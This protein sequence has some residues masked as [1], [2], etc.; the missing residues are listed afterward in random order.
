MPD[1]AGFVGSAYQAPSK[2]QNDQLLINW[3]TETDQTKFVGAKATGQPGERGATA[4]YPTPGLDPLA[5]LIEGEVRGLR[6]LPGGELM[7]AVSGDRLYRIDQDYNA[8]EAGTLNTYEGFLGI[9]DNG[10]SAYLTDGASRYTY[11]WTSNTFAVIADGPFPNGLNC[12]EVD[13]YIIYNRPGTNQWGCTDVGEVDS[14]ALN[15]GSKIGSADNIKTLIADHRQV[16]LIGEKTTEFHVDVGS[17]PFPFAIVPGTM[18]QHGIAAVGSLS[19]LGE[20]VAFL[21][22]DSR[23]KATVIMMQGYQ[24]K[25]ISTF[26]IEKAIN[27]YS[28]IDDAIAYTYTQSGHE[29]YMLTFPTA[30]KTWCYDLAEDDWHQRSWRDPYGVL[31]R[32]RSNCSASFGGK[33]VVGDFENGKLYEFSQSVYMDDGDPLPCIRRAPHITSD[34][35]RQFFSD[36]QIQFQPGVGLQSGQGDDPECIL[37][38]SNNGGF[39]FGND[40][41]LKLGEVGEYTRR[42]MKRKLGWGRDRVFE[43]EM[44]DPVYRVVVSANLNASAGAN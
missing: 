22:Q 26:A 30:D 25:R 12:D 4:L 19:R 10:S 24:P 2:T 33:I 7:L 9:T 29:F 18:M 37:R 35:R 16:M 38:W 13:N 27:D 32:H 31:H 20:S 28:R 21:A 43:I 40:H 17:F 15:L 11:D 23:G 8:L 44:T 36:L 42:A 41:I 6:T 39:T 5:E 34:L 1:F 14:G 3:Y